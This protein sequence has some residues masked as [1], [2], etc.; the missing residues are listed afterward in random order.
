M[1]PIDANQKR[2]VG[3]IAFT[4]FSWI[5]PVV[6]ALISGYVSVT[7]TNAAREA[8]EAGRE[9]RLANV[10]SRLVEVQKEALYYREHYIERNE[11][12]AYLDGL[13]RTM[14]NMQGDLR[15]LRGH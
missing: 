11:L 4:A 7:S 13:T 2:H 15:Y 14:E 10:E 8:R 12:K 6:L 9:Q 1:T 5:G 3:K